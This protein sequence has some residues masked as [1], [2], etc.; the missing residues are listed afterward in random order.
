METS[1]ANWFWVIPSASDFHAA[2]YAL[3]V[4]CARVA[5][6]RELGVDFTPRHP[7]VTGVP[8]VS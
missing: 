5:H 7:A 1:S 2:S 6:Q 3:S 8:L 4:T